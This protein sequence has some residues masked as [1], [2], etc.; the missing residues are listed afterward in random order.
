MNLLQRLPAGLIVPLVTAFSAQLALAQSA[1]APAPSPA[2]KELIAKFIQLQQPLID[3]IAQSIVQPPV[4]Q[5]AQ[6][7]LVALQ[8]VPAEKREAIAKSMEAEVKKFVDDNVAYLRDKANKAV[9]TTSGTM[10]EERFSEDE[11]RQ[12]I[13]W[14]E[15]PASK[16]FG[17]YNVDLQRAMKEKLLGEAGPTL[18]DRFKVLQS[19]M[20]KQLGLPANPPAAA[21]AAAP[22]TAASQAKPAKK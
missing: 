16:K 12:T 4:A 20:S 1:S 7:A 8:Q 22:S 5:L 10:L 19:T 2:K 6:Q 3:A 14:L 21:S 9:P 18:T 11:L 15:S 17:Q 13:A